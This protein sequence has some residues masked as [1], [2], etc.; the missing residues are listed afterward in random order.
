VHPNLGP[1]SYNIISDFTQKKLENKDFKLNKN[2]DVPIFKVNAIPSI[3]SNN[4]TAGYQE[5]GEGLLI[6][7]RGNK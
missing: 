1:G 7:M 6:L 2:S 4:I 5:I 3:P